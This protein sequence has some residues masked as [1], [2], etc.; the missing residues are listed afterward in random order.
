MMNYENLTGMS[1]YNSN[2]HHHHHHHHVGYSSNAHNPTTTTQLDSMMFADPRGPG[3]GVGAGAGLGASGL[4]LNS[5][6]QM[7]SPH[8]QM[9]GGGVAMSGA[10][11]GGATN[12]SSAVSEEEE[13]QPKRP[14]S[15][16]NIFFQVERQRLISE[17]PEEGPYT[18][19]EVYSIN[20][21]K[22]TR[23]E[24]SKRPHRKMHGRI[25]FIELAKTIA[26]K[27]KSIDG[28]ERRLFEERANDEKRKYA[29][30]LEDYL[31][32]QV[33]TQQVK[34]R[35]SALRRG[36]LAKFI[37]G[38]ER[39]STPPQVRPVSRDHSPSAT[40]AAAITPINSRRS[41]NASG[42]GASRRA[43]T[44]GSTMLQQQQPRSQLQMERGRNLER[45]Y[46]MQI[47]LYNEQMRIQAEYNR[48]QQQGV[49][50]SE[51]GSSAYEQRQQ[52]Q[53]QRFHEVSPRGF[54]QQQQVV[55]A[56]DVVDAVP[57][58]PN[59]YE[60]GPA[61]R[62]VSRASLAEEEEDLQQ[63][64]DDHHFGFGHLPED[65]QPACH[66]SEL[67]HQHQQQQQNH[68]QHHHDDNG[69]VSPLLGAVDPFA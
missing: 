9:F 50:S 10:N 13:D 58:M 29:I 60:Q 1:S 56:L 52:Q 59:M 32:R 3:A 20:L 8:L 24:K 43:S 44:T 36:S 64:H 34:K 51:Q 5:S 18:R 23:I 7:V 33:P 46:Q 45:L 6:M 19:T 4:H 22:A 65:D 37:T 55:H 61:R 57:A 38:R 68:H 28:P 53:Q 54:G 66:P 14:L 39:T 69:R 21:D 17:E 25:T 49:Y 63:Q 40:T 62:M 47:Q 41:S 15:A 2:D 35:L 31:L 26:T 30:E 48:E 16:Y 11:F 12:A 67:H 27:W 42:M